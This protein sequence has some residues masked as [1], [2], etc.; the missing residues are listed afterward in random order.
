[1]NILVT[2]ANGQLGEELKKV[3]LSSEPVDNYIFTDVAELNITDKGAVEDLVKRENIGAIINCAAYTDVEGA[4]DNRPKASLLNSDAVGYLAEAMAEVN[5]LL[6]HIS[7]DYVFGGELYN[8]PCR[9]DQKGCPIGVYGETKLEG[10][11]RVVA[12]GCDHL[13]FRTAWLYSEYGKNFVKTILS[14]TASRDKIKVVI[15]QCGTPTYAYDLAKVIFDIVDGRKYIGKSGIYHFSNEGVC[16]WYDFA[17]EIAALAQ[18]NSCEI[19][20]CHSQEYPSKVDRP[21]YSVLDKTK[22]KESFGIDVRYWRDALKECIER[23][24]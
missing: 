5:G 9:E 24:V 18:N 3:V 11:K 10:E 15:D 6:V 13:I 20:P 4:E 1:M 14:L 22:I 23:L 17:K 7:T 8:R 12:S 21:H 16:S 2:G 19:S